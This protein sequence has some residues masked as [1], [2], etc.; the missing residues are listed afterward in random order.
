MAST[1]KRK[2]RH[3]D[4]SRG[5]NRWVIAS[6]IGENPRVHYRFQLVDHRDAIPFHVADRAVYQRVFAAR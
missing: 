4:L 3:R 1:V 5:V 6:V 2:V